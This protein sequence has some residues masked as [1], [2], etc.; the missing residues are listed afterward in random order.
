MSRHRSE[1]GAATL[2]AAVVL[3]IL[4]FVLFAIMEIGGSLKSYSS[5]AGAVRSAGRAAS[6]AGADPMAD[7]LILARIADDIGTDN[8]QVQAV[9]IWHAAGPGDPVPV[10]CVPAAPFTVNLTSKGVTDGGTDTVGGCNMYILPGAAG[11]AFAMASGTATFPADHYFGCQGATDPAAA[12]KVDCK[13]PGKDRRAVTSPRSM[14]GTAKP[15][16]FVGVFIR[17]KHSY[18][19]KAFGSTVTFTDRGIS[20]IE[21]Q[22]YDVP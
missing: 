20:L 2:E 6:L 1:S 4:L 9:V 7:S 3:P 16:D 10:A 5:M 18:Y 12:T 11:G 13:W 15:T 14:V 19:T 22:G 17:V 21:P 8:G